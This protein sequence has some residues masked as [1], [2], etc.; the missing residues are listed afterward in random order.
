MQD[1]K[2]QDWDVIITPGL[3]KKNYWKDL[4]RYK[5]LFFILSWRDIKVRY[6]QTVIG[7]SWSIIRPVLTT[8]IFTIVFSRIAGLKNTSNAPYA[9]M[10]FSGMLPWQFFSN[11]LSESSN[12]LS[13][14]VSLI[15]KV[16]FPRLIIPAST[17]LTSLVDFFISFGLLI[18]LLFWYQVVPKW[19]IV[20]IPFAILMSFACSFGIGLFLSSANVKYRDFRHLIPFILQFGLYIS[21]VG[22]NSNIISNNFR[23]LYSL[24]PMVGVIDAF[25]WCIFGDPLYIPSFITSLLITV[26]SLFIGINYFKKMERTFADNI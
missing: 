19:Q 6:K 26:V 16:F 10:V 7:I 3:S 25:R 23:I 13:T 20:F 4:W 22:F 17:I 18:I 2:N 8:I 9:L 24:N 1:Q 15:T 5:E 11:S 14:N 21:P 12:S